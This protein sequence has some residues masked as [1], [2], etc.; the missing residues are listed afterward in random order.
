M[1][2][3]RVRMLYEIRPLRP[4]IG[5]RLARPALQPALVLPVLPALL[6]VRSGG[7]GRRLEGH[8]HVEEEGLEGVRPHAALVRRGDGGVVRY[9][10]FVFLAILKRT[11]TDIDGLSCGYKFILFYCLHF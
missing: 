6:A 9:H 5:A 3:K 10:T 4:S 7:G 2:Q 1:R 8:A 11:R